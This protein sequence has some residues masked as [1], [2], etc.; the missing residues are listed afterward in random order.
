MAEYVYKN[1][2]QHLHDRIKDFAEKHGATIDKFGGFD[3]NTTC[4]NLHVSLQEFRPKRKWVWVFTRVENPEKVLEKYR[5]DAD[6]NKWNGKY[7]KADNRLKLMES[8]LFRYIEECIDPTMYEG[9]EY[10]DF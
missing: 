9:S 7:N 2:Y 1:A 6:F 3:F 8:W 10:F 5:R 4:G